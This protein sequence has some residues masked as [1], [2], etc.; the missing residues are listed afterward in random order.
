[1][2]V[3]MADTTYI[4]EEHKKI[5]IQRCKTDPVFFT[6]KML[7]DETGTPFQL[8]EFQKQY[9]R[10]IHPKKLLFWGRRLSKSLMIKIETLHKSLFQRAHRSL[11]VSPTLEQAIYFGEDIQD[12]INMS[13]LI[14]DLFISTKA[15]KFKLKNNS[16]IYMATAGRGGTA[17]LGK[18]VHYL[19]FD[20]AQII[21]E[22]TYLF[23][24]PT[25]RGQKRQKFI[26][27]AGTPL[28]KTNE[29][30][31]AYKNAQYY[32]KMDGIEKGTGTKRDFIVFVRPTAI[33]DDQGE[34][35]ATT[36]NRITIEEMKEDFRDMS[37]A[38]FYREYCLRWMDSIGEVFPQHLIEKVIDHEKGPKFTSEK[39]C[40]AGLDLGKQRNKSVLTIA[41]VTPTNIDIINYIEWDLNTPYYDIVRS[42]LSLQADYPK[43]ELLVIDETGVGKGVKEIFE[44]ELRKDWPYLEVEGFDFSGLKKKKELVESAITDLESG[45]VKLLYNYNLITEMLDF[46][47]EVTDQGNIRYHKPT[48]GT[49]DYV[50]S[51]LLCLYGAR[52]LYGYVPENEPPSIEITGFRTINAGLRKRRNQYITRK[53]SG[54]II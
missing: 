31:K 16:R 38:G 30:Y 26:V 12:I 6:E 9:L 49:D 21:P 25:L 17:Q 46:K 53:L 5:F 28:A 24:R 48:G 33:L 36:T 45:K 11:V 10:C 23:V 15:T 42:I 35:I 13:P 52:L 3:P 44:N 18:N 50:D 47:R 34:P 8:E 1:M 54:G 32:I 7:C 14:E 29:F 4:T 51:L 37:R 43:L 40:I 20:E 22:E 27:Y 19:A 2:R 41:E 39:T